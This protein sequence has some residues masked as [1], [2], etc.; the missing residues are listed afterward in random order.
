MQDKEENKK[1]HKRFAAFEKNIILS[2]QNRAQ[3]I[4]DEANEYR[5]KE[6][7]E[8]SAEFTGEQENNA[9]SELLL[10]RV[11]QISQAKLE[12]RRR[13]LACREKLTY[14]MFEDIKK[15]LGEFTDSAQYF[16]FLVKSV[17]ESKKV[18]DTGKGKITLL[19]SEKDMAHKQ[20][21]QEKYP[22]Y[23]ISADSRIKIGGI[24]LKNDRVLDDKTLDDAL[25]AQYEEFL[26]YCNL[27][28]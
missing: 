6:L 12:A 20:K 3:K 16:D 4:L 27:Q 18:I 7:Q 10:Q 22:Q 23:D 28:L 14:D 19:L 21:L 8:V 26:G 25:L 13:L 9:R 2:A 11:R 5:E 24:K 15:S 1:Q 17:E